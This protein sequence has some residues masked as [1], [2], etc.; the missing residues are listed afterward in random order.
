[1]LHFGQNEGLF[2]M[3][4]TL[5]LYF[6]GVKDKNYETFVSM[7]VVS[8]IR[9][10]VHTLKH[11]WEHFDL[12]QTR[13]ELLVKKSQSLSWILSHYPSIF[14][15]KELTETHFNS[16]YTVIHTDVLSGCINLIKHS[17][18]DR[19]TYSWES[20]LSVFTSRT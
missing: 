20:F 15:H 14:V 16:E 12:K 8:V 11:Y 10:S 1:M 13:I 18:N 9:G 19:F 2:S 7:N 17:V 5:K 6:M 3:V 4:I